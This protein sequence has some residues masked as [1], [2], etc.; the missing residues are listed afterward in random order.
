MLCVFYLY[1]SAIQSTKGCIPPPRTNFND[2]IYAILVNS[3]QLLGYAVLVILL[4][5]P[6]YKKN[7]MLYLYN[8]PSIW[9]I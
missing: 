3:N 6:R 8:D 1:F 2:F 5:I 9:S 4:V 7:I